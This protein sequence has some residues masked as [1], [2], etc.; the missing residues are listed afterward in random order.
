L[1]PDV[2]EFVSDPEGKWM[3]PDH[4]CAYTLGIIIEPAEG[5]APTF[6]HSGGHN[7]NQNDAA[8]GPID[9]ARGTSF[10]L[11]PDGIAWFAS[12]D[13]LSAGTNPQA[14]S[15]LSRQIRKAR[16]QISSW[17]ASDDFAALGIG[18]CWV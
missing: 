17:P 3:D 14:T 8:G 12:Y 1:T 9:E 7:W 2:S 6:F 4:T 13:G 11:T 10:E 5:K 18:D 16:E 15:T